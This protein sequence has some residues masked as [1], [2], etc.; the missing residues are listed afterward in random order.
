MFIVNFCK[1]QMIK[2]NFNILIYL[3]IFLKIQCA[4]KLINVEVKIIDDWEE[5][6]EFIYFKNAE[7]KDRFAVK[8][9]EKK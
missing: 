7:I 6:R 2:F 8:A 3:I 4:G 5:K 1:F 9:I